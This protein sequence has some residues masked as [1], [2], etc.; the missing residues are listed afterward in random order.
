MLSNASSKVNRCTCTQGQIQ[1]YLSKV[2]G[3]LLDRIDLQ[4]EVDAVT[5]EDLTE[6]ELQEDSFSIRNRVEEARN[7]QKERFK[8]TGIFCNAQMNDEMIKKYC[9]LDTK[10]QT[11]L[12]MAFKNLKMSAR[13]YNRVLKVART[14][15]D[16]NKEEN[17]SSRDITLAISFRNLDRKYWQ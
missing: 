2:S 13:G 8:G 6:M 7:I 5:Y 1:K 14:I 15:A 3:P 16:L 9:A 11:L 4:V 12:E 17:I 10:S